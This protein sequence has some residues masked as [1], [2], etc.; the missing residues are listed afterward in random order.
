MFQL[1][2]SSI[3]FHLSTKDPFEGSFIDPQENMGYGVS[4]G[5]DATVIGS[6]FVVGPFLPHL[7]PKGLYKECNTS[8]WAEGSPTTITWVG[9][10]L[11]RN[12]RVT[13]LAVSCWPSITSKKSNLLRGK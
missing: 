2:F 13:C 7:P 12:I 1:T 3:F 6:Y 9:L 8:P 4:I 5:L 10:C 11:N